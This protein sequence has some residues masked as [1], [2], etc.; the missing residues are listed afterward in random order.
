[1]NTTPEE[2]IE[3]KNL[4]RPAGTIPRTTGPKQGGR[5]LVDGKLSTVG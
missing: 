4:Q 1:M 3:M 2:E 5:Y